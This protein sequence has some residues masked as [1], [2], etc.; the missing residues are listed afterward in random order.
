MAR[1]NPVASDEESENESG[2]DSP[3]LRQGG[4]ESVAGMDGLQQELFLERPENEHEKDNST[5][6]I[7]RG[8]G[9]SYDMLEDDDYTAEVAMS[10]RSQ[11]PSSPAR[12]RSQP[13]DEREGSETRG[14]TT[15]A[16]WRDSSSPTALRVT[17]H[18]ENEETKQ[19][20]IP[21]P[22]TAT[23]EEAG[24]LLDNDCDR[25]SRSVSPRPALIRSAS[26][27]TIDL[28]HPSPSLHSLQG[29]FST[30]VA[31]LEDSAERLSMTSNMGESIRRLSVELK[32]NDS[33]RSS[34]VMIET[35]G[36][37]NLARQGSSNSIVEMNSAA[38][39][40]GY[41]PGGFMMSPRSSI[42]MSSRGRSASKSSKYGGRPEPEQEGRPLDS[43][44]TVPARDMSRKGSVNE[45][46]TFTRDVMAATGG[47]EE[48]RP[49]TSASTTTFDQAQRMFKDFDG[50][51][52]APSSRTPSG[53]MA[54]VQNRM[55]M[56][57]RL[58][59]MRPQTYAD[60]E[61]G[62]QMVYYPAPVPMML[63]L[64]Q[65]LSKGPSA[66]DKRR[67]QVMSNLP[68]TA[69]QSAIWLPDVLETDDDSALAQ[70]A[71]LS[72]QEYVP[73]HQRRSMGGRR[74]MH[75]LDHLPP[76]LRANSYFELPPVQQTVEL[77][78]ESV[79][80]TLDSIL[81]ASAHAPVSAF[82]DHAY[83]GHLGPEVYGGKALKSPKTTS[84]FAS[85]PQLQNRRSFLGLNK[86][87]SSSDMLGAASK[88]QRRNT[89]MTNMSDGPNKLRKSRVLSREEQEALN[90]ETTPL[91]GSGEDGPIE[92]DEYEEG[93]LDDEYVGPP[94]TL[95]AELQ[96]RKQ[97]QKARTRPLTS[98]YA[99][100]VHSTLLELE[101]VAQLQQKSRQGKRITLAWEG[102]KPQSDDE[103][104]DVPLGMLYPE[105]AVAR[106]QERSRP[107]GLME[108]R[109]LEDSEPLSRRRERLTGRPITQ[110]ASTMLPVPNL[111]LADDDEDEDE[112]L[113]QRVQRI[114]AA[115]GTATGLPA[116]RPVSEAFT[117]EL[118]SQFGGDALNP[119]SNSSADANGKNN[120]TK[121]LAV[122]RSLQASPAGDEEEETLG[123]RRKRLQAEKEARDAEVALG[124][125]PSATN[126]LSPDTR[127]AVVKRHSMA[128]ILS[129]HP[130]P[131]NKRS[132]SMGNLDDVTKSRASSP[133]NLTSTLTL[134]GNRTS[135]FFDAVEKIGA[136]KENRPGVE[137]RKSSGK[138]VVMKGL[139]AG[140]ERKEMRRASTLADL[141]KENARRSRVM[142]HGDGGVGL[143]EKKVEVGGLLGMNE[144]LR[145]SRMSLGPGA[146]GAQ[147]RG[148]SMGGMPVAGGY[149]P[150]AAMSSMSL[151]NPWPATMAQ[152][153]AYNQMYNPQM[154]YAG[155]P[156]T[157]YGMPYAQPAY[158]QVYPGMGYAYPSMPNMAAY[159]NN[160]AA[161]QSSTGLGLGVGMQ[162]GLDRARPSSMVS[163]KAR[164]EMVERWRQSVVP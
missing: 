48:D 77:K 140:H 38:R 34:M 61:S 25:E 137:K 9:G 52:C 12:E 121:Y 15:S 130:I 37:D 16:S 103:D 33:R 42:S 73:Q 136:E 47:Y 40:G 89:M 49:T 60:P 134:T 96:L 92:I 76:Q 44:V 54:D 11:S 158:P 106:I 111:I 145:G 79:T 27:R 8:S 114:K 78:G 152:Y 142:E 66:R 120:K 2:R 14:N 6:G 68:P 143:R 133:G 17:N 36:L 26:G 90:Q 29:G 160:Y 127:P 1:Y 150:A 163:D 23:G 43:I 153:P 35:A 81:D 7:K 71:D 156:S 162:T 55:S 30:N 62:E 108:R 22:V 82:T 84:N 155:Y 4:F 5:L 50:V 109:D 97:Q 20:S 125:S 69:R 131:P 53:N 113:A 32:K 141:H 119:K 116:S 139:M 28:C 67:S 138:E 110:R 126:L 46:G 70:D 63:N 57:N 118:L 85:S 129:A 146:M 157:N 74:S 91:Q 64:P 75:D 147:T 80:A 159:G 122:D 148:M 31:R 151:A 149:N 39:S 161:A 112:T 104:D 58:S 56:G 124:S 87:A 100:G 86:R 128:D 123:Q 135:T 3:E 24:S 102:V 164:G 95:L 115:G 18:D 83:A 10:P 107:L 94:T 93:Q 154:A 13:A 144:E 45:E 132:V 105:G 65:K 72:G 59:T 19:M 101:T 98:V 88:D 41:S 99:N 21:G 51:H 117:N